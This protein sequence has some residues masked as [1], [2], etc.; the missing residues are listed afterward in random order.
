MSKRFNL[1][2]IFLA[3]FC[4][5][6][7]VLRADDAAAP[8]ETPAQ[9]DAR[10]AWWRGAR[11]GMFIH[12]GIY[13]VP[14]GTYDGKKIGGIGEWIMNSGEI[15]VS[16]YADYA[17]QF[18]PV[19]FDADQWV[20]VAKSAGMKYIVMTA[21]HHDGFCMFH[22]GV[23]DYNVYDGTP[24]HRDVIGEMSAAA[25]RHDMKFGC[26]YSQCQD[27]HHP[28]GEAIKRN[29]RQTE[30]WDPAQDG[31]FDDYL[32]NVSV[33]QVKEILTN[34]HPAVLWWDTPTAAMTPERAAL[35]TPLLALDPGI[36][37][38]NRLGGGVQGD[39]ETPEQ[40]IP[41][42]GFKGRDWETC[43]TMNDTWGYKSYDHDWKS[44]QTLLRNLI[45]IASK[46]GNYLLNVGP[47]SLG[48]I[49]APSIQR[50][51]EIGAWMRVN[52]ESIYDT[53]ASPF[54]IQPWG[55]C[56]KRINDDGTTTLYLHVFDWPAAGRFTVPVR[57]T[58]VKSYLL[59]EPQVEFATAAD[60]DEGQ[61]I[62]LTGKAPDANA[63]VVVMQIQG[64]PDV[65]PQPI[66][67]TADGT[68]NLPLE[69]ADLTGGVNYADRRRNVPSNLSWKK[70]DGQASWLV[71]IDTPGTYNVMVGYIGTSSTPAT[72]TLGD[73]EV[74]MTATLGKT[75]ST[76]RPSTLSAGQ[77]TLNTPGVQTIT[78]KVDPGDGA[79]SL[80]GLTLSPPEKMTPQ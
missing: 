33:P 9:K 47:N 5:C 3:I 29:G 2:G 58:V 68:L 61:I 59:I 57:N 40:Y 17:K 49:P 69:Y 10:M 66:K 45:D 36:I 78:V 30:H 70:A 32:K 60:A 27:W 50:L 19:K 56:T 71:K 72:L 24:F 62:S 23:D 53:T 42:T 51:L 13:S 8:A 39:T 55:R 26:Y 12:W 31:S 64:T 75:D 11:F 77:I 54:R 65:V 18:N 46:G 34:Y 15:P 20:A 79:V 21:K 7:P 14:A 1:I 41:A 16:V 80:M 6:A 4:F 73:Q 25:E 76:S 22:T 63:T 67:Q 43:M 44:T 48:Q 74:S 28:G 37:V 52:G 35:F 38:N